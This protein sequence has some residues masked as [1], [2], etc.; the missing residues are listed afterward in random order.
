MHPS[1][2]DYSM[3]SS[4]ISPSV[5]TVVSMVALTSVD[6][7]L[8]ASHTVLRPGVCYFVY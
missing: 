1:A 6:A 7:I 5:F 4:L 8:T 3:S 2:S